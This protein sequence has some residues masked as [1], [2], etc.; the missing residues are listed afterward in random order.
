MMIILAQETRVNISVDEVEDHGTEDIMSI[1]MMLGPLMQPNMVTH[2]TILMLFQCS[3]DLK[4][5]QWILMQQCIMQILKLGWSMRLIMEHQALVRGEWAE[6]FVDEGE[7][8][9]DEAVVAMRVIFEV[10]IL[11]LGA[12]E[13]IHNHAVEVGGLAVGPETCHEAEV[14]VEK[15]VVR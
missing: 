12:P 6:V 8:S 15:A 11:V 13:S 4:G 3:T 10:I 2:G 1:M 5:G 9:E 14:G 7:V